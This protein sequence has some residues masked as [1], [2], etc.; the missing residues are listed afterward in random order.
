MLNNVN[1]MGRLTDDPEIRNNGENRYCKFTIAFQRPA[2]KGV[3]N[4]ET[5]FFNCI[6]WNRNADVIADWY[7]KG[8]KLLIVGTLRNSKYEKN[9][10]KHTYTEIVV[11]EIHFTGSKKKSKPD[12]SHNNNKDVFAEEDTAF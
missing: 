2:R 5:D 10:K 8:D 1:I 6:A 9:G 11:K 12:E 7:S 4:A 3:D